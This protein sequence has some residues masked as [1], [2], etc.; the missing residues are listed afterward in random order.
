MSLVNQQVAVVEDQGITYLPRTKKLGG[1]LSS[2]LMPCNACHTLERKIQNSAVRVDL[3][4]FIEHIL[5]LSC[6]NPELFQTVLFSIPMS[7]TF[8]L[9][10]FPASS[11]PFPASGDSLSD[12][13]F[14]AVLGC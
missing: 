10:L 14:W 3:L 5:L 7:K 4:V 11:E 13:A 8:F 1:L 6:R 2:A 9:F 12:A